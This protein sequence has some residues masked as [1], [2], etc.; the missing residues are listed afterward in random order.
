MSKTDGQITSSVGRATRPDNGSMSAWISFQLQPQTETIQ[1]CLDTIDEW[2]RGT[3]TTSQ[4]TL[5]LFRLLPDLSSIHTLNQY[6][7][8]LDEI[9]RL[10]LHAYERGHKQL[11]IDSGRHGE[12]DGVASSGQRGNRDSEEVDDK[13]DEQSADGDGGD[14]QPAR[15]ILGR[16][17]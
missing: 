14:E 9:D 15:E 10:H 8:K 12:R 2:R 3:I 6:T 11:P 4:A 7:E 5:H 13:G 1:A 17:K 16:R